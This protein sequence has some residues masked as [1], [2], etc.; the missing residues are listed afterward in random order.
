MKSLLKKNIKQDYTIEFKHIKGLD[1][2]DNI[3]VVLKWR[4]GDKKENKGTIEKA[5]V[6]NGEIIYS[7][8][9]VV[10]IHCTLFLTKNGYDE[11]GLEIS[12][13]TT[14]KKTKEL[15]EGFIDLAKYA[16]LN[17]ASKDLSVKLIGK[18]PAIVEMSISSLLGE[19][20]GSSD[21]TEVLQMKASATTD[22]H[23]LLV[24]QVSKKQEEDEKEEEL[25]EK[26]RKQKEIAEREEAE[27]QKKLQEQQQIREADMF[28]AASS[29][30]KIKG[31]KE[32]D[33]KK[34]F[35]QEDLDKACEKA[36]RE[37]LK[38]KKEK[39]HKIRDDL[40]NQLKNTT[41]SLTQQKKISSLEEEVKE[42]ETLKISLANAESNGKQLSEVIEKNKIEREEEK[43]QVEQQLE[44]LKKE[45][46]EEENKK[47]ELKKQLEEEQKE[48]SNIK[49]ALAASEAVV[50]GLKAEV[51]KKENEITEQKKKDEQEK[52]ELKK[53]IEETEKNAAA[54]SEQ[55]LNQK[56]A[57]IEQKI[58]KEIEEKIEKQQKEVEESNKRCN[59]NI[60]I[61]EQ[62]KKDI[63]NIKEEKEELIKKN[64]EKE[65]EIKQVITQNEILKK[66]IEEF[67]NNKGDDIKTSVVLTE[68][69]EELTQGINEER[70][71]NKIIE[72]KYSKEVNNLNNKIKEFEENQK[73]QEEEK[74]KKIE[75]IKN[76]KEKEINELKIEIEN[77]KKEHKEEVLL[78]EKIEDKQ[79]KEIKIVEDYEK[80]EMKYNENNKPVFGLILKK[81]INEGETKEIQ[82][83]EIIKNFGECDLENSVYLLN[84][85][86][87]V[88][89]SEKTEYVER[90][91]TLKN[92][93]MNIQYKFFI[94]CIQIASSKLNGFIE[95]MIKDNQ[96]FERRRA[97][98]FEQLTANYTVN[99]LKEINKILKKNNTNDITQKQIMIQV[100]TYMSYFVINTLIQNDKFINCSKGLQLK[101]FFS[102]MEAELCE[103]RD[104]FYLRDYLQLAIETSG[105]LVL[106]HSNEH[107]NVKEIHQT[108]P[109]LSGS[110]IY[111]LLSR[112]KPDNLNNE[113]ID[114]S[115][116]SQIDKNDTP[117]PSCFEL[118]K[119]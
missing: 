60:V 45:K 118:I 9:Q 46:K 23:E 98:E 53:R 33:T 101:F 74:E 14:G 81:Y 51:E 36:V 19:A 52:E 92:Q 103:N 59:E 106:D 49:V 119:Y 27:R 30:V 88:T 65:E 112:F 2:G 83:F 55:I 38:M 28:A 86:I 97:A 41:E 54:G 7:P 79:E 66:R 99:Y 105:L 104:I 34:K 95:L 16:D 108:L 5:L 89:Q 100:I 82:E 48:K 29:S 32:K 63:E 21:E 115:V 96:C 4:R 10:H 62:Q 87:E 67:E 56:N 109:H 17:G 117:I 70:E 64:N 102:I 31:K 11:K 84:S 68:R 85:I 110:I 58:N 8:V 35:T 15:C 113:I 77:L 24:Q 61:I 72:E 50:V 75:L 78:K 3:E 69:I 107:F 18:N 22:I 71:K 39:Y 73:K 90:N 91:N 57:E 80:S 94:K 76:D 44:E 26:Q 111:A 6:H 116:L 43:K 37:A 20:G 12:L 13:H 42:K 1:I 47:E 93:L 25:E 114:K 40:Q